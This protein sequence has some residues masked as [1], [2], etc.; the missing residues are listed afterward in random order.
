MA[1]ERDR[2]DNRTRYSKNHYEGKQKDVPARRDNV[3]TYP[4]EPSFQKPRDNI[5]KFLSSSLKPQS[6][7]DRGRS[8]SRE[9]KS[10]NFERSPP[11]LCDLA[12]KNKVL[13]PEMRSKNPKPINKFV[14]STSSE[15]SSSSDRTIDDSEAIGT[16]TADNLVVSSER[17]VG[18][19]VENETEQFYRG[20]RG[21]IPQ[22]LKPGRIWVEYS[23]NLF[24]KGGPNPKVVADTS[25]LF[26]IVSREGNELNKVLGELGIRKEKR[27]NS[28]KESGKNIRASSK[29]V[30]HEAV[31]QEALDLAKRDPIRLD[32]QIRSSISQFSVAWKSVAEVLKLASAD[33]EK[34]KVLQWEKFE[35]GKALQKDQFEKEAAAAKKEV[36]EEA[37][38]V[39]DIVVASRNKLIQAFYF[40]GLNREDVDLALAGKNSKIIFPGDDSSPVAEQI[41]APP[42]TD[43]KTEVVEGANS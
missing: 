22:L 10:S 3:D 41:P 18:M 29:G 32:T 33:L 31:E 9:R 40:W 11:V 28:K 23:P 19:H 38:K 39:V 25:S 2:R 30:N 17:D 20:R 43:D 7:T 36:E 21:R 37:K 15:E 27:L 1:E 24:P 42:A 4:E 14:V 35:K 8:I 16:V 5:K 26:D 34:D 12:K 6:V 13:S